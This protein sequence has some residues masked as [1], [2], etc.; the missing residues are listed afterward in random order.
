LRISWRSFCSTLPTSPPMIV[1]A[2]SS[3]FLSAYRCIQPNDLMRLQQLGPLE[4]PLLLH[5]FVAVFPPTRPAQTWLER[6]A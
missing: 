6:R 1:A 5:F 4:L 2:S 3:A